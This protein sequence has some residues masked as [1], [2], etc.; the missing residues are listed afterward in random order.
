MRTREKSFNPLQIGSKL[1]LKCAKRYLA[2]NKTRG[3][4][5]WFQI[6]LPIGPSE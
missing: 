3:N 4:A 1:P 2:Q 5:L 6:A